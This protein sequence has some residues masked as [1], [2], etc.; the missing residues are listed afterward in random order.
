MSKAGCIEPA[1]SQMIGRFPGNG[2]TYLK[3]KN[4]IPWKAKNAPILP[5]PLQQQ[6]R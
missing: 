4:E 1:I 2:Y 3:V 6:F 5:K